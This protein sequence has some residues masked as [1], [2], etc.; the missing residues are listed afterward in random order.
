MPDILFKR[1][2]MLE[3]EVDSFLDAI[4]QGAMLF[5]EGVKNY[6]ENRM[7]VFQD[8]LKTLDAKETEADVL[9]RGIRQKLYYQMLIPE[10][11]GD[12]LGL[13]ENMDNVI[14]AAEKT[15][16]QFDVELPEIPKDL[17][18]DFLELADYSANAVEA[19]VMAARAF[20]KDVSAVSDY[21]N[22]V[23]FYEKEADK[24]EDRLKRKIFKTES[25]TRLSHRMHL[26][27]FALHVGS[28]SDEAE[29]VCERLSVYAIK[30]SF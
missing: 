2:K 29:E 3:A 9:R 15:L 5:R 23:L 30:R 20:F 28:L 25:I 21:I 6:L 16:F 19:L 18:Q 24:A 12:V 4:A 10:A 11:R 22:K 13:L 27:Y 7:D 17:N 8:N 26:R 14:D 1:S